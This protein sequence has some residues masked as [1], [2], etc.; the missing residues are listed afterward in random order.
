M[1]WTLIFCDFKE[2]SLETKFKLFCA[3]NKVLNAI[4]NKDIKV[5]TQNTYTEFLQ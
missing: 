1:I 3:L 4:Q 2:L 5:P